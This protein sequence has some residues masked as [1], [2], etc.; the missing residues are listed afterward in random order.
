[1]GKKTAGSFAPGEDKRRH[2][3]TKAQCRKGGKRG[4][5][6]CLAKHGATWLEWLYMRAKGRERKC[7]EVKK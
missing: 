2:K 7:V 1:M 5:A 3:F 6:S 4:F